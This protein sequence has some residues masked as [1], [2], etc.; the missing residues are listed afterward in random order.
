LIVDG[1]QVNL[2][3]NGIDRLTGAFQAV[4]LDLPTLTPEGTTVFRLPRV[5]F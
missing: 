2:S 5:V 1:H 3:C 4:S